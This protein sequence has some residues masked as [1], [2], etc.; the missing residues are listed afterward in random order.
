MFQLF[1]RMFMLLV[2]VR[3]LVISMVLHPLGKVVMKMEC[4]G[5]GDACVFSLGVCNLASSSN[6][7]IRVAYAL[8]KIA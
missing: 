7:S 1:K 4:I 2:E 3:H 6:I 5:S 8:N